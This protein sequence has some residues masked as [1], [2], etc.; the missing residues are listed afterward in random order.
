MVYWLSHTATLY[1]VFM[2]ILPLLLLPLLAS[3]Y[4]E[5]NYEGAKI[6]QV[7]KNL[8]SSLSLFFFLLIFLFLYCFIPLSTT[9]SSLHVY[10][11]NY[12]GEGGFHVLPPQDLNTW[13]SY[14]AE[15]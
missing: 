1:G 4:A 7:E 5:V 12:G 3:S 9:L 15:I 2:F 13:L 6:F 14:R 10:P 8:S 11:E